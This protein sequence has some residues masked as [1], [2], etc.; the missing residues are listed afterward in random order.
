MPRTVSR[1]ACGLAL[2]VALAAA[3]GCNGLPRLS[4]G[5]GRDAA[6]QIHSSDS[7]PYLRSATATQWNADYAVTVGHLPFA[8]SGTVNRCSSGCDLIFFRHAADGAV[9]RWRNALPGESVVA[10]GTSPMFVR[11]EGRGRAMGTPIKLIDEG[12][13]VLYAAHD[14]P[15]IKGMSGGPVYGLDGSVLGMTIGYVRDYEYVS[16]V[17]VRGANR[18]SVYL[19]YAAIRDEWVRYQA[20]ERVAHPAAMIDD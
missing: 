19:P 13:G 17:E 7:I 6:I 11:V 8:V 12:S 5:D 1:K 14:A 4:L 16:N 15:V 3:G 10:V 2:M 18:V 9:P 20:R